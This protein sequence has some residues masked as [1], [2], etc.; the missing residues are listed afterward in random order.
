MRTSLP[1]NPVS[2]FDAGMAASGSGLRVAAVNRRGSLSAAWKACTCETASPVALVE[3]TGAPGAA[4]SDR[5]AASA[6]TAVTA[7]RPRRVPRR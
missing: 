2:R 3:A 1:R 4:C 6:Q 7:T 5:P